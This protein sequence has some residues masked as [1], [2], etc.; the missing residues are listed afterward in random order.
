MECRYEPPNTCI[1]FHDFGGDELF[2]SPIDFQLVGQIRKQRRVESIS[3]WLPQAP[4]G[5]VSLGCVAC[6]GTPRQSDFSSLRCLRSDM[7][8]GDQ[9]LEAHATHLI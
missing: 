5:F 6:K 7:V 1:F 3:F 8:T 2:K 9:F 4:P